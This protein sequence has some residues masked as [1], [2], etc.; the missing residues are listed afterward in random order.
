MQKQLTTAQSLEFALPDELLAST[1]NNV[2][3]RIVDLATDYAL[4]ENKVLKIAHFLDP[5]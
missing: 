3:I 5:Q 2:N 1:L 4:I